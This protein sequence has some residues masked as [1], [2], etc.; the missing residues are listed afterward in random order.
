MEASVDNVHSVLGRQINQWEQDVK[1]AVDEAAG[2]S[3]LDDIRDY[4]SHMVDIAVQ[5]YLDDPSY[6]DK[7]AEKIADAVRVY[8]NDVVL[9]LSCEKITACVEQNARYKSWDAH[10][11][12]SL[13]AETN[14]LPDIH[15]LT[16]IVQ[17]RL[18][19]RVDEPDI[20]TFARFL[21]RMVS[22]DVYGDGYPPEARLDEARYRLRHMLLTWSPQDVLGRMKEILGIY[23]TSA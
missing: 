10:P 15:Y 2:I 18:T 21:A 11:E 5:D 12:F 13:E 20:E 19:E 3:T 23:K 4:V 8:I 17:Q 22:R 6:K 9:E 1:G 14:L 7:D 16:E